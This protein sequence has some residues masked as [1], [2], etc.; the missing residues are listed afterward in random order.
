MTIDDRPQ[1]QVLISALI[2]QRPEQVASV[3]LQLWETL[4]SELI[5]L[6]GKD[7]FAILFDRCLYL[8]RSSFPWLADGH[9]AQ[10][11]DPEFTSLKMSLEGRDVAEAGEASEALFA[12]FTNLLDT[13]IGEHL[14]SGILWA[15]WGAGG[16]TI[17]IDSKEPGS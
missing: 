13:L 11:A 10:S 7:G 15:A 5:P 16:S 2:A 3:T 17:E 9:A 14:T 6:I 8:T 12:T 4:A 1:R